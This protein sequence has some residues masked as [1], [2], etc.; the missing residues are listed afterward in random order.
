MYQITSQRVTNPT[1][2]AILG[3]GYWGVNYVR[4]FSELPDAFVAVVCDQRPSRLEEVCRRFP[5]VLAT[6]DIDEAL[7]VPG[8]EAAVVATQAQT[9]REVASRAI[10]AGKHV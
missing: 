3:C 10:E 8:V 1:C 7:A 2:I 5:G 6:T 9:H 4:V